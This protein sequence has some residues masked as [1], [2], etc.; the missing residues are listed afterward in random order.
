MVLIDTL[1]EETVRSSMPLHILFQPSFFLCLPG[2][3]HPDRLLDDPAMGQEFTPRSRERH[4]GGGR[5][6]AWLKN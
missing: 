5:P 6:E 3:H 2:Y 4:F 1:L